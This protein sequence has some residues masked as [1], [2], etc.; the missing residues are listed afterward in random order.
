MGAPEITVGLEMARSAYRGSNGQAPWERPDRPLEASGPA[1]SP[2]SE[3]G[4]I[5]VTL[6][7][8]TMMTLI[9]ATHLLLDG[10]GWIGMGTPLEA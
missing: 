1:E 10:P 7:D 3:V 8:G 2:R 9:G 5:V 4:R 6:P